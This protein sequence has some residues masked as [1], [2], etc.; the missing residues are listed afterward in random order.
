[1][2]FSPRTPKYFIKAQYRAD[3]QLITKSLVKSAELRSI[4]SSCNRVITA[5]LAILF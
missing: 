2:L 4:K 5:F 3:I 1:M